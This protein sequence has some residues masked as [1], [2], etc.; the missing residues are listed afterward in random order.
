MNITDRAGRALAGGDEAEATAALAE[1]RAEDFAISA[2]LAGL[3]RSKSWTEEEVVSA[4]GFH[5]SVFLV[6][7][8]AVL[9]LHD[10][11]GMTVLLR[12]LAGRFAIRSYDWVEEGL[13][14]IAAERTVTAADLPEILRPDQGNL[15]R[16]QALEDGA[17]LDLFAPYY[18]EEEGRP[19]TY[20]LE[21]GTVEREGETLVRLTPC[22]EE[23]A[24]A[25]SGRAASGASA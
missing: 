15:H 19:C 10:H 16:I 4:P 18:S 24:L 7:A 12:T 2:K 23:E 25:R 17:F 5:A 13:A 9:P 11:P 20:Y 6:P 14:R 8:G 3:D 1:I 22:T 21:A